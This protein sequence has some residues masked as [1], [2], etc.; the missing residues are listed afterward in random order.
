[1]RF[2]KLVPMHLDIDPRMPFGQFV[3]MA[4]MIAIA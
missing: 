3:K 4:G 2:G 1:M